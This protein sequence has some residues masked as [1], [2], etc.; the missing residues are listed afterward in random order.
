VQK[1]QEFEFTLEHIPGEANPAASALSRRAF[2]T[3]GQQGMINPGM[4]KEAA[5]A[6][7][8]SG[9]NNSV[10]GGSGS[11]AKPFT[12]RGGIPLSD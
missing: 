6:G 12:H 1:L 4:T 9:S 10:G 5:V 7:S 3:L 8:S 2:F 11:G